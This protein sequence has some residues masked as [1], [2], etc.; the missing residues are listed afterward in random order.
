MRSHISLSYC[1]RGR[2]C[3]CVCVCV[4]FYNT[5]PAE[6]ALARVLTVSSFSAATSCLAAIFTWPP[7]CILAKYCQSTLPYQ[8]FVSLSSSPVFDQFSCFSWLLL[9]IALLPV[10]LL[11]LPPCVSTS[12]LE[13]GLWNCFNKP[14][15]WIL[16]R[17]PP[18]LHYKK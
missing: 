8:A 5:T 9:W 4:W 12:P 17:L 1:S 6:G 3:V 11:G 14:C 18:Q 16:L 2:V 7:H 10:C 15:I 13:F